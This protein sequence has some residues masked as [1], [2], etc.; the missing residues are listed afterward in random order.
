MAHP[1]RA[2]FE[3]LWWKWPGDE[4]VLSGPVS[5]PRRFSRWRPAWSVLWDTR[6]FLVLWEC[7]SSPIV[8]DVIYNC[9]ISAICIKPGLCSY[10]TDVPPVSHMCARFASKKSGGS[11]RNQ[12]KNTEG[13][14]LG[15]K[16][17]EGNIHRAAY[18]TGAICPSSSPF[19]PKF[20]K[21]I[22]P[23]LQKRNV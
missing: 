8:R 10:P 5:W 13:K 12:G 15:P 21:Y 7:V 17:R 3:A 20:K 19:T 16:R 23:N 18:R 22:P 14:R 2:S 11:T 9:L 1:L 4:T 6:S